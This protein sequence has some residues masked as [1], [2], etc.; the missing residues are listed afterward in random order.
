MLY[1]VL[2]NQNR[3]V[4]DENHCLGVALRQRARRLQLLL[5][6]LLA[7]RGHFDPSFRAGPSSS[8]ELGGVPGEGKSKAV[9]VSESHGESASGQAQ[10]WVWM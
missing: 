8:L 2:A 9:R 3:S 1:Y 6:S 4:L 5:E 7:S 10:V